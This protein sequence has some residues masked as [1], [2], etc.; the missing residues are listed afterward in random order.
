MIILGAYQNHDAGA[1]LFDDYKLIAAVAEERVTRV[2]GDGD[3]FPVEAVQECLCQAGLGASQV[4]VVALSRG[5][6]PWSYYKTRANWPLPFF[7]DRT[8]GLMRVMKRQRIADPAQALDAPRYLADQGLHPRQISFF[9]H[10]FA[11]AL[12]ALFHTDYSDALIYTSDGFGDRVAYSAR[13]LVGG[14]LTTLFGGE[15]DT[16]RHRK[17]NIADSVGMLYGLTTQALGFRI[18]RHE[19]KVL[20]LAAF[21]EPIYAERLLRHYCVGDDG[22]ITASVQLAAIAAE[23][24]Q[25][26]SQALR[27]DVAA[28]AQHVLEQLTLAS[29]EKIYERHRP[30]TLA[31]SGGV[32]ANVKLTQRIIER[33]PFEEVFVSPAMSDQGLAE[34]GALQFLLERDGLDTFLARR[35]KFG[36]IYLGRDYMA[37]AD[38]TFLSA[39]ASQ[40]AS[41]NVVEI[42]ARMLADRKILGLYLGRCEYGPR[43][44][45]ART[46]MASPADRSINDWL[47]KR[48][49]RTEFM[50]FAPVVRDVR[51]DEIFDLPK[52]MH[53]AARHMTVTCNVKA[54]WRDRIPAVVHVDGTARPQVIHREDNPTYYDI[55]SRFEEISGLPCAINTSFNTHEEP[56]INRPIEAMR[57]LAQDRI[58]VLIT[59][60]GVFSKAAVNELKTGAVAG[61]APPN[62][63][64]PVDSGSPA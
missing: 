58:D 53:Y 63:S 5:E 40:I 9:N 30:R 45:G 39:G 22:R 23:I 8:R 16:Q 3:R 25:I 46:I 49:E 35:E 59:E 55:L 48:L 2:K 7:G 4:E 26:V 27:E 14:R 50:P 34:G 57:A 33:F 44:L 61:V 21:G 10:H 20:G 37:E 38:D 56:I 11:H 43:A 42:A 54:Q 60:T 47:N 31:A 64:Y 32:F 19:G 51:A 28:S 62:E 17:T 41:G 6:Y 18:N 36:N 1:A 52:A 12:S 13:R 15:E 24:G 29:L